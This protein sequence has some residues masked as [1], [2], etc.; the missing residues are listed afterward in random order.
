MTISLVWVKFYQQPHS[1]CHIQRAHFFPYL[2]VRDISHYFSPFEI[3]LAFIS[4]PSL[5]FS[6]SPTGEF[7]FFLALAAHAPCLMPYNKHQHFPLPQPSVRRLVRGSKFGLVTGEHR[8]MGFPCSASG[9]ESAWQC[10]RCKRHR[11]NPWVRKI[12][13]SRKWKP[14]PVFLPGKSQGQRRLAGYSPWGPEES[15]TIECLSTNTETRGK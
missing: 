10:R 14:T 8:K 15:D 7:R 4:P 12:P 5:T 13:L 1:T 11:F 3:F 6:S 9:R 2:W